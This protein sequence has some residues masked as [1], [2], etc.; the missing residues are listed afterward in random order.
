M[1]GIRVVVTGATGNVGTSL[2]SALA[3]DE[4][5][6]TVVG[7]ARR[8]A[9]WGHP[10]VELSTVDV[11]RD[12][13]E[14]VL[15]G[16]DVVVHLAWLFQP[17]RDPATTW[18]NN[19]IGSLRVFDAVAAAGVPALVYASS[20]GAYSPGPKHPPVAED[21]PT[22]GWPGAAYTREKAYLERV[23]DAFE[24]A[25]PQV[26]V[27]RMRPGFMFKRESASEQRRLFAGPLLPGMLVRPWLVPLLPDL[28]GLRFQA[29]HTSDAADG[30]RRAV[31][32]DVRGAVNLAAEPV[33]DVEVL[34]E[35]LDA[36]AVPVSLPPVRAAL[37][38]AWKVH[39]VPAAPGLF[40]AVPRLPVMDCARAR[41]EL[42]WAPRHSARD[43]LAEFLAGLREGAGLP[44][45]PLAPRVEGGR[46]HELLRTGVGAR[47]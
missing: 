46:L 30:F 33:V 40:D 36:R 14:P 29:L 26:R 47:P 38:A 11:S 31:L 4:R 6:G 39:A 23:L 21:W 5:V 37:A 41:D 15:A 28:P 2:V 24:L 17:T 12:D 16:A 42:G 43:A 45:P 13:L 7:L 8:R 20:V 1:T 18:E 10:G 19:V 34:A 44:T 25:H 22:H 35:L 27:V 32:G 3:D 9:E